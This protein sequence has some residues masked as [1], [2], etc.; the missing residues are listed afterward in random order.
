MKRLFQLGLLDA[1][2]SDGRTNILYE[3]LYNGKHPG[4]RNYR[5]S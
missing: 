1:N 3:S 2:F 5:Y 4:D